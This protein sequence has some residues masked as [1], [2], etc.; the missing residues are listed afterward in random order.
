MR[1]L[2]ERLRE[3]GTRREAL[4]GI[5]R[6]NVELVYPN[7][8]RAHFPVADDKL[9]TKALL[10]ARG[11]PIPETLVECNGLYAIEGAVARLEGARDF[12]VKPAS[13]SGGDGILV[14]GDRSPTGGWL[15]LDRRPLTAEALK[16]H[17]A[18]IVFGAFSKQIGDRA[19]AERRIHPHASFASIWS[20]G[21][22]DIRVITL[23]A[24][25]VLA[26]VRVPTRRSDGRANLH[27]GG[28]GLAVDLRSGEVQRA[29]MSD[30]RVSHHP[31]SGAPLVGWC[32]PAWREVLAVA[33]AAARA[34]PLR[35]LGVDLVVDRDRGPLVLELNAR[36]GLEI[37]NVHALG[38]AKSLAES[39]R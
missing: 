35:Y 21:L 20:Q 23:G 36:P 10:R 5:N 1:T 13:G 17:L 16:K 24:R 28:I 11:V 38:L 32:L 7:N 18:D 26:M 19:Y 33:V 8:P 27:Q 31:D 37:Q 2:L 39:A 4:V 30:R 14:V 34:V 22:S 15:R 9:R 12:V 6:R 25:P 3:L 29:R